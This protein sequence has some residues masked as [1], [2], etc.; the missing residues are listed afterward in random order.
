MTL[1]YLIFVGEYLGIFMAQTV[2]V[3]LRGLFGYDYD[4]DGQT[5]RIIYL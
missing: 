2:L 1:L 3:S 5:G 4:C